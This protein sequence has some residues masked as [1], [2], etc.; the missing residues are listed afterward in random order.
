MNPFD[1]ALE[2]CLVAVAV[3]AGILDIKYKKISGWLCYPAIVVGLSLHTIGYGMG[4][5]WSMGL[6]SS[7]LGAFFCFVIFGAFYFWG[8]KVSAGDLKI[9][10][11][12]GALAGLV[13]A[14]TCLM[15]IAIVG[16][17]YG[18]VVILINK[19]RFTLLG[20]LF[21]IKRVEAKEQ[22]RLSYGVVISVGVIWASLIKHQVFHVFS[23]T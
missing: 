4:S 15:C 13:H 14:T 19:E 16:A 10:S 3:A 9:V 20:N 18:L 12:C 23:A 11:A 2:A 21:R 5:A 8:K 1:L 17:I 6:S 7:V 22:L